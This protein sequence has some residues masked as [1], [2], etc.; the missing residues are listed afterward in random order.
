MTPQNVLCRA[1]ENTVSFLGGMLLSVH[2]YDWQVVISANL[3]VNLQE[4]VSSEMA[5]FQHVAW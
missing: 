1:K 5:L 2:P 4:H 3:K